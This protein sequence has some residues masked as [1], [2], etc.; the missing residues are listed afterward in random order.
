M[1]QGVWKRLQGNV[2]QQAGISHL[3]KPAS[4]AALFKAADVSTPFWARICCC[5]TARR[6][7]RFVLCGCRCDGSRRRRVD[8]HL[9]GGERGYFPVIR[10]VSCRQTVRKA[11]LKNDEAQAPVVSANGLAL[12][13]IVSGGGGESGDSVSIGLSVPGPGLR[14]TKT[15]RRGMKSLST[16]GAYWSRRHFGYPRRRSSTAMLAT[17]PVRSR[18]G[19]GNKKFEHGK[20]L[21]R[22]SS[23]EVACYYCRE[24]RGGRLW[25]LSWTVD[26]FNGG[27]WKGWCV[28]LQ[29]SKPGRFGQWPRTPL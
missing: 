23:R 11:T 10:T 13:D 24:D 5:G 2:A 25:A 16:V 12:Q 9:G 8:I 4:T 18:R 22:T 1:V 17:R 3:S 26:G 21:A 14:P 20:G 29:V 28:N 27:I 7:S 6:R 19:K 15:I